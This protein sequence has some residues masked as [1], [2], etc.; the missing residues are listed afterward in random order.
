MKKITEAQVIYN[1]FMDTLMRKLPARESDYPDWYKERLS[2]CASCKYNTKNVPNKYLPTS[3]FFSKML[4]KQRCTICTCFLKQKCWSKTEMCAMGETKNRPDYLPE[5]YIQQDG[6]ETPKW[7]RL[8]LITMRQDEF[9]IKSLN[10]K[11]YNVDL[12]DNG[13]GF[14]FDLAPVEMGENVEFDFVLE[15]K[16]S[17][18]IR[19]IRASCQCTVPDVDYVDD[20]H[21]RVHVKVNTKDFGSG[22]FVKFFM[23]G[24]SMKDEN[25]VPKEEQEEIEFTIKGFVRGVT[26]P[27]PDE[28]EKQNENE[29]GGNSDVGSGPEE[30]AETEDTQAGGQA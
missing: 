26:K 20:N 29:N 21:I 14:L 5:G 30:T 8:E 3:L 9:N 27:V 15:T 25:G 22:S 18:F 23:F 12:T 2:K 7:N 17:L 13:S 1:A 16:H 10:D 11:Y 4:G 19:T 24:Y 6:V 28:P